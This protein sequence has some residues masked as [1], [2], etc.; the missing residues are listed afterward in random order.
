MSKNNDLYTGIRMNDLNMR[1]LKSQL[2]GRVF[3]AYCNHLPGCTSIPIALTKF[4][5]D[6]NN[7]GTTYDIT[8]Y[9]HVVYLEAIHQIKG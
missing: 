8:V 7:G 9:T 2:S 4:K 1:E 3:Y 5:E 6:N